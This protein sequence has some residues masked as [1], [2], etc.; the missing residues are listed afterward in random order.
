MTIRIPTALGGVRMRRHCESIP[1][2]WR[3][4]YRLQ[5]PS[6]FTDSIRNV[7]HAYDYDDGALSKRRVFVDGKTLGP[8]T[9]LADGLTVDSQGYVWSARWGGRSYFD[10]T[11]GC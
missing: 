1:A 5:L 6:Y 4:S 2:I 10:Y 8:G 3:R 9:G 7:I 11:R